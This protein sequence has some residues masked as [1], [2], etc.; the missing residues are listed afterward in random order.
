L[1]EV[2]KEKSFP[3]RYSS[4]ESIAESDIYIIASNEYEP[5]TVQFI[6]ER[7]AEYK[8]AKQKFL[9]FRITYKFDDGDPETYLGITGPYFRTKK[10]ITSSEVAGMYLDEPFDAKKVD[11]H[12]KLYLEQQQN[13]LEENIG[14]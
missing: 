14:Q 5:S 2:G 6:G 10:V 3:S 1:V 12:L 13:D 9:L 7:M 4:Q 8:G 11:Q